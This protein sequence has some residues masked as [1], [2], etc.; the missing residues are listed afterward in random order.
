VKKR[1]FVV[2]AMVAAAVA[3]T[4]AGS[5]AATADRATHSLTLRFT[6]TDQK[7]VLH[8]LNRNGRPD[9]GDVL[10]FRSVDTNHSGH[11]VG[12]AVGELTFAGRHDHLLLVTL[13]RA[14]GTIDMQGDFAGVTKG[15]RGQFAVT[16]GTGRFALMRGYATARQ[17][18]NGRT[19]LVVHLSK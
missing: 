13:V 11:R 9:F 19:A 15:S 17:T 8:D 3:A 10:V 14:G 16:G 1:W 5:A 12:H 4:L 18:G 2:I 6:D 7:I